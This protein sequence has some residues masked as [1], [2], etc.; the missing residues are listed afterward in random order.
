[1]ATMPILSG[2]QLYLEQNMA[3]SRSFRTKMPK[4]KHRQFIHEASHAVGI[5]QV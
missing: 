1:M 2:W 5:D 4:T 3:P